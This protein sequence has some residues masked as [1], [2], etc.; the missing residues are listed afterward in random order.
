MK[1]NII[2][3]AALDAGVTA[4]YVTAIG[5]FLF[6]APKVFGPAS[7]HTALIPIVM[8]LLLV[9]SAALTGLLMFGRPILW[10]LEERKQEA[11]SLLIATLGIFLIIT[12]VA[13]ATLY[14][15]A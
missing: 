13:L 6:Y 8:L 11:F 12:I 1:H 2:K 4:L 9:F 14:F 15:V 5:S 7:A 3:N 10:Y